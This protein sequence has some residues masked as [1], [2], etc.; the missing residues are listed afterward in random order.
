MR[1]LDRL[2]IIVMYGKLNV[3][4][5]K[6]HGYYD[7]I[8]HHKESKFANNEKGPAGLNY[9]P[10]NLFLNAAISKCKVDDDIWEPYR[11]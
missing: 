1:K 10:E 2:W 7:T 9:G 6:S 8:G 3:D 11:L 4:H 5:S